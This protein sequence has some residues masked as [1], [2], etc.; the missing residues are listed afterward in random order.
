MSAKIT[1]GCDKRNKEKPWV[2]RWSG[3]FDFD[4]GKSKRYAKSFR[5]KVEAEQF[6]AQQTVEFSRGGLRDESKE[7]LKPFCDKWLR[8][9]N[10]HR[11]ATQKLYGHTI[12]RLLN[13]F[14]P[15][16]LLRRITTDRAELFIAELRP[17]KGDKFSDW[18][19]HRTLRH[20]KTM[21]QSAVRWGCIPKNLFIDIEGPKPRTTPWHY[22]TPSEYMRLLDAAPNPRWRIFYALCYTGGLRFSEAVALRWSDINFLSGEVTLRNRPGTDKEPEFLLKDYEKRTVPLP[23]TTLDMLEA[24]EAESTYVVLGK[25]QY[26]KMIKLW[27]KHRQSWKWQDAFY[28]AGREFGRHLRKAEIEPAPGETLSIHTLRK[29]CIQN[30]SNGLP[31]N[32]TR[33]LAGHSNVVTT[34]KY[35]CQ[36][37]PYY[38]AKA[39]EVIEGLLKKVDV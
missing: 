12:E 35:Y 34:Q 19:K 29:S 10:S 6:A 28:N 25:A 17:L 1:I 38:K 32:V 37:D 23:P 36:V 3:D 22:I 31:M 26:E 27:Q 16:C 8:L 20:C 24:A 13:Y 21:F 9:N 39:A 14:G 4:T 33:D 15:D 5:L 11:P 30:W 18:T 7:T 2:C